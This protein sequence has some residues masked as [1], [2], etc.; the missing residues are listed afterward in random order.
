MRPAYRKTAISATAKAGRCES[1]A[2][3]RP[4]RPA[5]RG[6]PPRR[7]QAAF[8]GVTRSRS[9]QHAR[10]DDA[11]PPTRSEGAASADSVA[12]ACAS[13]RAFRSAS[14]CAVSIPTISSWPAWPRHEGA[15][16][17]IDV[18][19][20]AGHAGAEIVA[21]LSQ[22]HHL[23]ASHVFAGIGAGTLD[24]GSGAGGGRRAARL[25][26]RRRTADPMSRRKA[27]CCR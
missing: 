20:A 17:V 8:R 12:T 1:P 7:H 15:I 11:R 10:T 19:H 3:G 18:S 13:T 16:R 27:R 24:H 26:A 14:Q 4:V 21:D 22:N 2:T 9:E 5:L 6:L 23:A 25:P